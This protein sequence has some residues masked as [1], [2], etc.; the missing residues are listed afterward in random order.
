MRSRGQVPVLGVALDDEACR[1]PNGS[2]PSSTILRHDAIDRV[3]A[4]LDELAKYGI[5]RRARPGRFRHLAASSSTPPQQGRAP[6]SSFSRQL[7]E[8]FT[9]YQ[10]TCGE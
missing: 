2:K 10:S 4:P 5:N 3:S 7:G 6:P 1:S 9:S 8:S